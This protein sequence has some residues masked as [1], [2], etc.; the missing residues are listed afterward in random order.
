[1]AGR[2]Y[3]A[4]V[5][6]N[7]LYYTDNLEILPLYVPDASVDLVY[8]DPSLNSNGAYSVILKDE[9]GRGSDAPIEFDDSW[10]QGPHAEDTGA[11]CMRCWSRSRAGTFT[12]RRCATSR[13]R[14]STRARRSVCFLTL[15]EPSEP[16]WVEAAMAGL[17][18]SE[19]A[20]RD[21]PTVQLLTIKELLEGKRPALPL[22]VMPTYP[23][24]EK[25]QVAPGQAE[26][27]G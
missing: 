21:Y 8:L 23:Q 5:E 3:S 9:S 18:H 1:V 7:V 17:F 11:R 15:E 6:T 16:R 22:L 2:E 25:V 10:H 12:T 26:L 24:A 20:D 4:P 13:A 19:L 27:F 14:W